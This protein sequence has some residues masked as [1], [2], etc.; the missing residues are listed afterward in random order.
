MIFQLVWIPCRWKPG[1]CLSK[2]EP[3]HK[4]T[5]TWGEKNIQ[6]ISKWMAQPRL[7]PRDDWRRWSIKSSS[8]TLLVKLNVASVFNLCTSAYTT[9]EQ[10]YTVIDMYIYTCIHI[11]CACKY[12]VIHSCNII[13]SY[14][15]IYHT[16]LIQ[17]HQLTPHITNSTCS[18]WFPPCIQQTSTFNMSFNQQKSSIHYSSTHSSLILFGGGLSPSTQ[19]TLQRPNDQGSLQGTV[20][21]SWGKRGHISEKQLGTSTST[22][23]FRICKYIHIDT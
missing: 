12:K 2:S 19:P 21:N 8:M 14:N 17:L 1:F 18:S 7:A 4:L 20:F 16:H 5:D 3:S 11:W 13:E 9:I 6:Q 22:F 10:S 15:I 23:I